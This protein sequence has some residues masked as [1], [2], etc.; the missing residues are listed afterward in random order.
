MNICQFRRSDGYLGVH[1][2]V[3]YALRSLARPRCSANNL[4]SLSVKRRWWLRHCNKRRALVHNAFPTTPCPATPV[5]RPSLLFIRSRFRAV[6]SVISRLL[7]GACV[8]HP[9]FGRQHKAVYTPAAC[10]GSFL[11]P[12]ARWRERVP[13]EKSSPP[14]CVCG[15]LFV[16]EVGTCPSRV[17]AEDHMGRGPLSDKR[18]PVDRGTA[19]RVGENRGERERQ[20]SNLHP[21][22]P[23]FQGD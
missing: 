1:T 21:R 18:H 5:H 6:I 10:R 12:V 4:H 15:F 7:Y 20:D 19:W 17:V 11:T 16:G 2:F 14:P 3:R 22:L 9:P 8:T 23:L 13:G